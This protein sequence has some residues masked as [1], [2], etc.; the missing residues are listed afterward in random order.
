[1]LPGGGD[2]DVPD[3]GKHSVAVPFQST[4]PEPDFEA[5]IPKTTEL[6]S[7]T[8]EGEIAGGGSDAPGLYSPEAKEK[9]TILDSDV[10]R[11]SVEG[12]PEVQQNPKEKNGD[13]KE[14]TAADR[15]DKPDAQPLELGPR[16]QAE[17]RSVLRSGLPVPHGV[18]GSRSQR[19]SFLID[20]LERRRK[21]T[22]PTSDEERIDPEDGKPYTWGRYLAILRE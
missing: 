20:L 10:Q 15:S 4:M 19:S 13:S 1:M 9:G 2:S 8:A 12:R 21:A 3:T 5:Q 17:L 22:K 14:T 6:Q 18:R 7:T 11:P 16:V